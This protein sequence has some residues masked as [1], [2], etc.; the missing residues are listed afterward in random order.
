MSKKSL[1]QIRRIEAKADKEMSYKSW[2]KSKSVVKNASDT[3]VLPKDEIITL[4]HLTNP[5]FDK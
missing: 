5:N 2:A 4:E 1:R 3:Q